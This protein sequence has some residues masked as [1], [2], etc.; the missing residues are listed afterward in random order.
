MKITEI[1]A[2]KVGKAF[3]YNGEAAIVTS[4]RPPSEPDIVIVEKMRVE[5]PDKSVG[6]GFVYG[7]FM[8]EG[9]GHSVYLES[10]I[11]AKCVIDGSMYEL[12]LPQ[13]EKVK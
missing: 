2:M 3:K 7:N 11:D 8:H 6:M 12:E 1:H 10:R 13:Y 9:Q 4:V 5:M